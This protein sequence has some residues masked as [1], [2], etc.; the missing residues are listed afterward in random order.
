MP[1]DGRSRDWHWDDWQDHVVPWIEEAGLAMAEIV[2]NTAASVKTQLAILD[3]PLPRPILDRLIAA[4]ADGIDTLS[5]PATNRPR[6]IAGTRGADG[7]ALGAG[8][9]ALIRRMFARQPT[10]I[11]G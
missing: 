9:L 11:V 8:Q 7:M 4:T 2:V 6:V 1:T 3:G 5:G 10:D